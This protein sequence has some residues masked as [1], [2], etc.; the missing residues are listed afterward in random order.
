MYDPKFIPHFFFQS[1]FS[2]SRLQQYFFRFFLDSRLNFNSSMYCTFNKQFFLSTMN[3]PSSS[4]LYSSLKSRDLHFTVVNYMYHKYHNCYLNIEHVSRQICNSRCRKCIILL[5]QLIQ[6][7]NMNLIYIYLYS[8]FTP[9]SYLPFKILRYR[10]MC[11]VYISDVQPH[12][13]SYSEYTN[14]GLL[15][16]TQVSKGTTINQVDEMHLHNLLTC[17]LNGHS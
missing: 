16:G 9:T 15:V 2:Q 1:F 13:F 5:V 3:G 10:C 7:E 6:Q 14:L 17:R 8:R 12:Y 11:T 4:L